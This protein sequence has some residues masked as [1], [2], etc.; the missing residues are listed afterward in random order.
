MAKL[1]F[2]GDSITAGAWDERGGW[3]NRISGQI[4]QRVMSDEGFYCEP[5]NLGI[6]G[7]TAHGVLQ[8]MESEIA[9]RRDPY[10]K[11]ET[12]QIVF[13]IG[14]N[15]SQYLNKANK[16]LFSDE[17]FSE[18]LQK[19][20]A[21]AHTITTHISFVGP[22]PVDD[23]LVDPVPWALGVSYTNRQVRRIS[24]LIEQACAKAGLPFLSLLDLWQK[25]PNYKSLLFDGCHPNSEGHAL[26]AQQIG[27]WLLTPEFFEFHKAV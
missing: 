8:R 21:K 2:F 13:A 4:M 6:S 9:A 22:L 17:A 26:M 14:T 15:D 11:N 16:P 27:D 3:A 12:I 18:T 25:Q 1:F 10:D 20:I 19:L 24:R 5:Y 23:D 7:D